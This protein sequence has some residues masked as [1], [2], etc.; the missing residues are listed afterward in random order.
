LEEKNEEKYL[1]DIISNDGRNIKNIK[2][3]VSKGKGINSKILTMLEGIPFGNFYFE[4]AVIL[5]NSLL[6]SS[7]LCNS[8]AW[9]NVTKAELELLE[10]VDVMLLRSILRAPKSTPK[11]MLY[12]ELGCVPFRE[13]V[14]KRRLS[15]LYYIL[16]EKPDSMVYKFFEAQLRNR[17]AKDWV[18]A[19]LNDLE[20]L[21]VNVNFE[22]I[23]LM[24]KSTF[25]NMIKQSIQIKA[26]TDLNNIKSSHSKVLHIKHTVLEMQR[27]FKSSK[28]D[29]TQ[30]EV[31]LIFKL[32]CRVTNLKT[33]LRG[34][35]DSHEF[36]ICNKEDET[37]EHILKCKGLTNMK[38]EANVI[39][40][41]ENLFHG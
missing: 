20:V 11:E 14:R 40:E 35:Y 19:V 16:H 9:Y 15:F 12:L 32:R 21:N 17:T 18:S 25:S 5:R 26:L 8:E 34:A 10:S 29:I 28:M 2:A 1:G 22:E 23:K 27:Y 36:G 6:V 31:R 24:K 39:P 37:Q 33:N 30:E 3:R 13:I 4:V 38:K 41:Y 7:L